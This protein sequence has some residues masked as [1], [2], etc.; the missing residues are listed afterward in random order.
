MKLCWH[1]WNVVDLFVEFLFNPEKCGWWT[2]SA[3]ILARN[4]PN[5]GSAEILQRFWRDSGLVEE[6]PTVPLN[7][8]GPISV[9]RFP[10]FEFRVPL[11]TPFILVFC[12]CC[13]SYRHVV[14]MHMC[15]ISCNSYAKSYWCQHDV[16]I[17][18]LCSMTPYIVY[19]ILDF[20]FILCTERLTALAPQL[21][22]NLHPHGPTAPLVSGPPSLP[23]LLPTLANT[24][25]HEGTMGTMP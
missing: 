3:E 22:Y 10:L 13:W 17:V 12:C 5:C 7:G 2:G 18:M 6:V 25:P 1:F 14:Y 11:F 23:L 8:T 9:F 19:A 15:L 21:G 16:W 4:L 20:G 24:L